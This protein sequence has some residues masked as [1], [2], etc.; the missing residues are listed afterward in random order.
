[1]SGRP[2]PPHARCLIDE[3]NHTRRTLIGLESITRKSST[4]FIN[5]FAES[6]EIAEKIAHPAIKVMADSGRQAPGTGSLDWK[7]AFRHLHLAGYDGRLSFEC[8]W[9]DFGAQ[10]QASKEFVRRLW[11]ESAA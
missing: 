8:Q 9:R 2:P 7:E 10:V 11:V 1:M 5:T 6:V 4:D 3:S